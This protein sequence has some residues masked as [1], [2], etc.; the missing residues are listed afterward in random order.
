MKYTPKIWNPFLLLIIQIFAM[1]H[2][3]NA[4]DKFFGIRYNKISKG[5]TA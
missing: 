3:R 4:L 2:Q 5:Q 1:K